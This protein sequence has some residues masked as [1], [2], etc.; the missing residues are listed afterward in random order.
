MTTFSTK[1]RDGATGGNR[2]HG[3]LRRR[4]GGGEELLPPE[5]GELRLR[6]DEIRGHVQGVSREDTKTEQPPRHGD[7]EG[8]RVLQGVDAPA[9]ERSYCRGP[10]DSLLRH[11]SLGREKALTQTGFSTER[12]FTRDVAG[13]A[14]KTSLATNSID[15]IFKRS[16]RKATP[17][18]FSCVQALWLAPG[19]RDLEKDD[20]RAVAV[21]E[22]RS[23]AA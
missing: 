5:N 19:G 15:D 11:P 20:F 7:E 6:E 22:T 2:E 14:E 13:A 16:S 17:F 23:C 3:S 21:L 8:E 4:L 9:N 18:A 12:Q 10:P 1:A